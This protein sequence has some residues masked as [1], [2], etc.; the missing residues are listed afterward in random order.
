MKHL[1][2]YDLFEN[3]SEDLSIIF[4]E[5]II[6]EL[7]RDCSK[8]LDE[9]VDIRNL[10]D[11]KEL[12]RTD[13]MYRGYRRMYRNDNLVRRTMR[14]DRKSMGTND[15][16]HDITGELSNELFGWNMRSEG[17]FAISNIHEASLYGHEFIFLPI[18]D[19][20]Y[21][22]NDNVSDYTRFLSHNNISYY[23][24]DTGLAKSRDEIKEN[25]KE[26]ISRYKN[27]DLIEA[28]RGK[29][30]VSFK[31]KEYYLLNRKFLDLYLKYLN[32]R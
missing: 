22:Y 13:L 24:K 21:L 15:I 19:Y 29:V 16:V 7:E 10:F 1:K 31:C 2:T 25:L 4:K 28:I 5:E 32:E 20:V 30:E 17:A 27:T 18:G 12:I 23:H 14:F 8:Y 11:D 3:D 26:I 9:Y 6:P